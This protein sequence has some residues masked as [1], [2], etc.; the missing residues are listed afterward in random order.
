MNAGWAVPAFTR[1]PKNI[2]YFYTK[3]AKI[4]FLSIS[5]IWN[6][7][8]IRKNKA[9]EGK[10]GDLKQE[11]SC[12]RR[13][14]CRGSS[15]QGHLWKRTGLIVAW[16]YCLSFSVIIQ[17]AGFVLWLILSFTMLLLSLN[18]T[19]TVICWWYAW[20]NKGYKFYCKDHDSENSPLH[21][22]SV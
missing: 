11:E 18:I 6:W 5:W 16:S 2:T 22:P 8:W 17:E 3:I 20:S 1:N 9:Y 10:S 13:R 21:S 7:V 4:Y 15:L 19:F 12:F 14:Y